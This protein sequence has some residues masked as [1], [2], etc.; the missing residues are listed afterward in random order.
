MSNTAYWILGGVAAV[1]V[2]VLVG[3]GLWAGA[4]TSSTQKPPVSPG[5]GLSQV[6]VS[7]SPTGQQRANGTFILATQSGTTI[8]TKNFL[9][10]PETT[11][12]TSNPGSYYIGNSIDPTNPDTSAAPYVITYIGGTNFFSVSLLKEPINEVR[13]QAEQYLMQRLGISERQMCQLRYTMTVPVRVSQ[14]YAGENLGFSFCP[15]ASQL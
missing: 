2:A 14:I 6:D 4:P 5:S 12:D 3:W 13:R 7:V 9:N 8:T 15:G 10:D 11:A 1:A